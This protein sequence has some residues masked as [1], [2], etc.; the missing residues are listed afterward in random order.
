MNYDDYMAM[1]R[2]ETQRALAPILEFE[3]LYG[4]GLFSSPRVKSGVR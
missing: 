3:R 4:R 2:R 1:M